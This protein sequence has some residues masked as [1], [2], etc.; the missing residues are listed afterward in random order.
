MI[1]NLPT[2]K[3]GKYLPKLQ[4]VIDLGL[5]CLAFWT[6]SVLFAD[7]AP[8]WFD[9]KMWL[10]L[11]LSV[12]V[13]MPSFYYTHQRRMMRAEIL[14][15]RSLI[16]AGGHVFTF[17]AFCSFFGQEVIT[18]M[19]FLAMYGTEVMLLAVSWI[20]ELLMLKRLR[21]SG[22]NTKKVVVV[23]TGVSAMELTKRLYSDSGYGNCILGYFDDVVLDGFEGNYL[24][25][26]SDLDEFCKQEKVDE[27]YH[28]IASNYIEILN[29]VIKIADE[30]FCKF[31]YVPL[32]NPKLQ[33][34]FYMMSLNESIPAVSVHPSPLRNSLNRAIKRGFDIVFSSVALIFSPIVFIPVAIAIKLDSPGPIF[35]RQKRT[36]YLGNEFYC[37]K[38]RTMR[39][40]NDADNVQAT[41]DDA[42]KTRL[43]NFL[44][45]SSID[46]LPQFWN[47][48]KGDMSVVGP[49]PHMLAHTEAYCRLI[50]QYMVRHLVKPGITGWAQVLGFRGATD[51]LWQME[52]RVDNDVWYIEHWSFL[53]D[54]KIIIRTITNAF[55]GEENAY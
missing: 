40:N 46:E 54:M 36:G 42:R 8:G 27:I 18:S 49:R 13:M 51:Q 17:A 19:F 55:S 50:D 1:S 9:T 3:Y 6:L 38:F 20:V 16:Y 30:N 39:V 34:R 28:T 43:G 24:G 7:E 23:G 25:R 47:V 2:G 32:M 4:T 12:L 33:H 29:K 44:R 11:V 14:V 48:L 22:R 41:K 21:R 52:R 45:H 15:K 37:Y 35:F 31:F 53:L 10:V 26:I 5:V